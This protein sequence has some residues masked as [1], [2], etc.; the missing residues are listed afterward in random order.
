MSVQ[1]I[2]FLFLYFQESRNKPNTH[3][4]WEVRPREPIY[5]KLTRAVCHAA[6]ACEDVAE[7]GRADRVNPVLQKKKR[8]RKRTSSDSLFKSRSSL[9]SLHVWSAKAGRDVV[10]L[11]SR[12]Y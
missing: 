3:F 7:G 6:L 5:V 1:S 2:C 11:V 4:Y 9:F 10:A 12:C 8:N